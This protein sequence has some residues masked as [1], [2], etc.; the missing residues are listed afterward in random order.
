LYLE[1]NFPS[2]YTEKTRVFLGQYPSRVRH[3]YP[4]YLGFWV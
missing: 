4:K 1:Y 2:W 3:F